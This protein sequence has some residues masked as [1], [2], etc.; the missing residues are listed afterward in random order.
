MF[1]RVTSYQNPDGRGEP[2]IISNNIHE[3]ALNM[4]LDLSQKINKT[5]MCKQNYSYSY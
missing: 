5:L 3:S 2:Q 4:C 1:A